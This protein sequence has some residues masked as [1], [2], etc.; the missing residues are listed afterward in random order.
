MDEEFTYTIRDIIKMHQLLD[1]VY[2][3]KVHPEHKLA[4]H[5][6][7]NWIRETGTILEN[8]PLLEGDARWQSF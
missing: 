1:A 2:L 4:P 7:S 3:S 6:L 8:L 5:M